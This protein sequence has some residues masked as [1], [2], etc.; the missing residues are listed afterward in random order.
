VHEEPVSTSVGYR[1]PPALVVSRRRRLW[2]KRR[3]VLAMAYDERLA[4]RIR[5]VVP[6]DVSVRERKMFGGL[7]FMLD[8]H[9][10]CGVMGPDL[11]LRIGLGRSERALAEAHVRRMDFTG[12]PLKG[13][14]YV[15][16]EGVGSEETL[17]RWVEQAAAFA[18]TLPPK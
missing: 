4:E 14:V 12:K 18:A 17:R 11:M 1:L 3:E 16:P 10:A 7:A 5:R 8:G 13:F 15:A 2:R 9:M 6:G